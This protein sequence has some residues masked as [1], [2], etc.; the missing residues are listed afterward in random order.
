MP[1]F[2]VNGDFSGTLCAIDPKPANLRASAAPDVLSLFAQLIS[3]NLESKQR[4]LA[5]VSALELRRKRAVREGFI[6]VL[7]HDLRNR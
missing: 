2:R 6:A 7:G 1:I 4:E 3:L 5:S